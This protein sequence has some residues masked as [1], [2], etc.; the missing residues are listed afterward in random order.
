VKTR[1]ATALALSGV[2]LL[3]LATCVPMPPPAAPAAEVPASTATGAAPPGPVG[4]WQLYTDVEV[5]FSIQ[6]PITWSSETLPDQKD[7]A[8][9]GTSLTG[10]EGGVEVYWGLGFG[11]ACP[12]GTEPVQLAQ[13]EVPACH[14]S[15]ADGTETWS[16]IGYEVDGGNSFSVRAYTNDAQPSSHD[17]V[18]QVLSTLT[19]MP[20]AQSGVATP[21]MPAGAGVA[22]LASENCVKQGG[23]LSILERGDG[24]QFGVCT[25]EDNQQC[26]EW[27]LM[28]GDCPVGGVKVTGYVT[29]AAT[30]CAITGGTYAVTGN[31]G[32]GDEQGT[33]TLPDGTECDAW[34]YY[35]H[36]TSGDAETEVITFV[37]GPPTGEPQEGNCW[38]GSQMVW[39]EDAWRCMVGNGI[40]DPCF[41]SGEDVICGANPTIPTDSFL[42]LL[43]E[44]LP[45][46][47]LPQDTT[48]HAW[49][50]ELA[51]GAICGYA[52]GATGG[53][54]DERI[55]YFCPSPDSGQDVVILG[56]L[57][58]GAVW[59]AHRAVLT[60]SMPD[61]TVLES[62]EVPVRTVWR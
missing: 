3:T 5:G 34:D 56:D 12:N 23:T 38:T 20:P 37:P 49:Q 42:L 39:R 52:T 14:G 27:A 31:S 43:T 62:A 29:P 55:N 32:A 17:L 1:T 13:A 22:N 59:M 44:P 54:G 11:G 33:C 30:Y 10:P 24:G 2:A 4:D 41:S 36:G 57:H 53:V 45:A 7:G 15:N 16:Q 8:I 25:F 50:A 9:H 28:R 6:V 47:E 19:F 26:E 61:L 40:Y 60:G 58:P 48:G 46:P 21:A 35:Y 18:L 51:D